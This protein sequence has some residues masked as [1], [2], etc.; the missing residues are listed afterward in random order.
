MHSALGQLPDQPGL[1]GPEEDLAPLR[2]F[3]DALHIVEN[4]LKLCGGKIGVDDQPGLCPEILFQSLRLQLIGHLRSPAALP[5]NRVVNRLPGLLI[6]HNDG[7]PLIGNPN[8][9][10]IPGGS[11]DLAHSLHSHPKLRGPDLVGVVF[12]PSGIWKHLPEFLLRHTAD[13]SLPVEENAAIAGGPRIQRHNI[14]CH[15][16]PPVS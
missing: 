4:P 14:L 7:L 1:H 2:P 9:G 15:K 8:P 13:I 3:S 10:N 6:P 11:A 5:H 16:N 12:H